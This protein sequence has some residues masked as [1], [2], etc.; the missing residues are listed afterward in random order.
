[1]APSL[2]T[3]DRAARGSRHVA[4][5]GGQVTQGRAR[6]GNGQHVFGIFL[7]V[8]GHAQH[9]TRSQ[10]A[11]HQRNELSLN[12]A[13]LVMAFLVPRIGEIEQD[14]IERI[15]VE[16]VAQHLDRIAADDTHVTQP[17]A[18]AP[19][20]QMSN[21]GT[22]YLDAEIVAFRMGSREVGQR[23]PV[24]ETN[25]ERPRRIPTKNLI[26][27]E[28]YVGLGQA[29]LWPEVAPGPF[30]SNCHA[31]GAQHKTADAAV[32]RLTC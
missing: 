8:R 5:P 9:S 17:T 14:F 23:F 11:G 21:S 24:A 25:F 31:S 13:S 22:M 1:M 15:I 26:Q 6:A 7:P 29:E 12:D 20:Q 19:Q 27:V 4:V 3:S 16:P 18:F 30:L 28:W 10:F 32:N 2:K